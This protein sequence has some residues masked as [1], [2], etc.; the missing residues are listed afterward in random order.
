MSSSLTV[1]I[2]CKNE[3]PNIMA[4]IDSVRAV[5]DEILI[6]DSGSTDG[7]LELVRRDPD[8][9]VIEREYRCSADFKNWAIP[10]ASHEWILLLD[11]DERMTASLQ[12]EVLQLKRE[13]LESTSLLAFEIGRQSYILGKPVRYSGWQNDTVR[14][15]FR[16]ECRYQERRVHAALDVPRDRTQLLEHV[17]EHHTYRSL[18]HFAA[19]LTQY[20]VWGAEDLR[21]ANKR[22]GVVPMVCR[23]A[24]RFLRQYI[25]QRGFL[26]GRV[27]L[28]I[29]GMGAYGVFLKY[30]MLWE[31]ERRER[32]R[33][34]RPQTTDATVSPPLLTGAATHH[35]T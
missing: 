13:T 21:K 24:W 14:R 10:Q 5:A 25:F 2:P 18:A 29:S 7:T 6:A 19:K 11:A 23:P 8:C 34:G 32:S 1:I 3:Q 20:A 22:A 35:S 27:G 15:L 30:A 33:Q 16:R 31:L 12:L 28:L 17:L 26:D 9:R 4:C